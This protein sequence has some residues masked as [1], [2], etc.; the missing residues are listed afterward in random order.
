M[1]AQEN[2]FDL[3]INSLGIQELKM[4]D[5]INESNDGETV[6]KVMSASCSTCVCCCSCIIV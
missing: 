1:Q 6:S 2:S 3:S 5:F 4:S